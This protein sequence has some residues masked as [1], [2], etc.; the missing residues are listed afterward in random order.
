MSDAPAK[1]GDSA[2]D[3]EESDSPLRGMIFE[4]AQSIG[5]TADLN[6]ETSKSGFTNVVAVFLSLI[7][8]GTKSLFKARN[9]VCLLWFVYI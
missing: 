2:D 3:T 9:H 7:K 1:S 4:C 5:M 6:M 8:Y